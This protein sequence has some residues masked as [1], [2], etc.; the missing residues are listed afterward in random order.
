MLQVFADDP[1]R[2]LYL[3]DD[4]S[5]QHLFPVG[6]STC[7]LGSPS[8]SQIFGVEALCCETQRNFVDAEIDIEFVDDRFFAYAAEEADLVFDLFGRLSSHRQTM[9]SGIMPIPRSAWTECWVGLV[10]TSPAAFK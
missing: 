1:D 3:W 6:E 7:F 8:M 10:F 9:I 5:C 4:G 2:S